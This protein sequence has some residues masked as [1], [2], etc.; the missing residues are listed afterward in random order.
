[1]TLNT[2]NLSLS[3]LDSRGQDRASVSP[4]MTE[5]MGFGFLVGVAMYLFIGKVGSLHLGQAFR[6]VSIL[7]WVV[8]SGF[9]TVKFRVTSSS[10]EFSAVPFGTGFL[11]V[12]V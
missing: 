8:K 11:T 9:V 7:G 4:L 2:S 12:E 3:D 5:S 1:M 6:L 10:L